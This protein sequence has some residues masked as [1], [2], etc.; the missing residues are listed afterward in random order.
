[1]PLCWRTKLMRLLVSISFAAILSVA[2]GSAGILPA[3]PWMASTAMA[4]TEKAGMPNEEAGR[5]PV[6]SA[7]RVGKQ[8]FGKTADGVAVDEYTLT[9]QSGA[10]VKIITYGARGVSIEVRDG[11]GKLGDVALGYDNIQGYEKDSSYSGAIVGRY[12][13]RIGKGRFTLDGR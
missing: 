3:S 6:L 12:G 8:P 9:N 10:R 1:M 4:S 13:N 2:A 5:M 11:E 7:A